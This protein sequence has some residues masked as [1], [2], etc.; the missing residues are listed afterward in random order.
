MPRLLIELTNRCNL[1]CQHCFSERHAGTGDLPVE[2]LGKV[3]REGKSCDIDAVSFTGGE[4]TLHR[5]FAEI[6]QRVC[7][8][9]YPFSFVSHGGTFPHI[10]QLLLRS[11]P[12]FQGVTFSLDGA[13]EQKQ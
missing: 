8:A 2:I 1:R 9:G 3:L 10:Y 13:R 6:V 5:R 11:R 4:P 12:W 7:A